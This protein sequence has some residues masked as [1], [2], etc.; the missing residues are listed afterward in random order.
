MLGESFTLIL[1]SLTQVP[2]R[3][4]KSLISWVAEVYFVLMRQNFVGSWMGGLVT[5]PPTKIRP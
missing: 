1:K 2:P 4:P 3:A 5:P